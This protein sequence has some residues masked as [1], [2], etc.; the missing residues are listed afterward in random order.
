MDSIADILARK[1]F[2]PPDEVKAIKAYVAEHYDN[3]DVN[4]KIAN[5]EEI[6]ILSR[7][8]SLIATLRL[9]APALEKAIATKKR[10]R[11]MIG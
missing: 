6:V 2:S 3:H 11:F 5:Q 8:A 10:I 7:S 9:N 4:V 1:D